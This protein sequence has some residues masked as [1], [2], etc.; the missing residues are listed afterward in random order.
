MTAKNPWREPTLLEVP[1]DE[2][3][4]KERTTG[5]AV[6][7]SLTILAHADITRIGEVF[8]TQ[9]AFKLSRI[10]PDFAQP[11]SNDKFPLADSTL[12]RRAINFEPTQ[13]GMTI[14]RDPGAA[15]LA[16]EG[17]TIEEH[18]QLSVEDLV[19]GVILLLG[20]RVCLH[21]SR[22]EMLPRTQTGSALIGESAAMRQLRKQVVQAAQ[23][24]AP[25]LITGETGTGKDLVAR[26][27]HQEGPRRDRP[28][29]SVNI[30]AVPPALAA[31]ELFGHAKG[32]F[33]G[34]ESAREGHFIR[35]NGG[36][37][38]LDEIGESPP[39]VQ[40]MLLRTL[41][42]GVVQRLG[43]G[44]EHKVNVR[45]VTA[46]DADLELLTRQ[47]KFR[48]ALV[49]RLKGYEI[50]VPSLSERREDRGSGRRSSINSRVVIGRETCGS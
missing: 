18:A 41:E 15:T 33:T 49:H 14:S 46:T 45:L 29:V 35:A 10:S 1:T 6:E 30:A 12:S 44:G 31:S 13:H 2:L 5:P 48:A 24:D 27:L 26:A 32:A 23:V 47:N 40:V 20:R 4:S 8:R 9:D 19:R 21:L 50:F 28:F 36:T 37:L 17:R 42:T 22:A 34:A 39:E 43:D 7:L 11:E 38:F 3:A 25:V 16:I